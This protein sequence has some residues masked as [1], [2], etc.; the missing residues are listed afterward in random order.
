MTSPRILI[1]APRLDIG[2][3]EM[4]LARVL[5]LLRRAMTALDYP[6]ERLDI[7]FV[8]EG[9]SADTVAAVRALLDDPRFELVVVPEAP[10]F[11]KPKALDYALPLVRG[12]H[13]VV[14]DAEDIPNPDQLRLA[15]AAFAVFFSAAD[16]RAIGLGGCDD[17]AEVAVLTAPL[18]PWRGAPLRVIVAVEK[19]TDGELSLI[20]PD[21]AVAAASRTRLDGPPYVWFAEVA[22]PAAGTWRAQLTRSKPRRRRSPP[23][24]MW[25]TSRSPAC[26]AIATCVSIAHGATTIRGCTPGTTPSPPPC[27]PSPRP[28]PEPDAGKAPDGVRGLS[29]D[30]IRYGV[31]ICN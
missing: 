13:V 9:R 31:R 10:P 29:A 20:G 24:R 17:A 11:T 14:Y 21:G 22:S 4:H 8:V 7:K 28:R 19:P 2:G 25:E 16:A 3:T 30:A 23:P 18:S 26:S 6:P 1:V 12:R 5:P 15:A 27:R